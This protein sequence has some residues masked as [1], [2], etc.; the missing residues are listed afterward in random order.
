MHVGTAWSEGG[1]SG[2]MNCTI[3]KALYSLTLFLPA[4]VMQVVSLAVTSC[5]GH[6]ACDLDLG[7]LPLAN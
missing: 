4:C 1:K 2:D 5:T 6:T 3:L 7:S